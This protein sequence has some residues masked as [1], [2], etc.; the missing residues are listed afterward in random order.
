[1]EPAFNF[2]DNMAK[3]YPRFNDI[4]MS[5]D[6]NHILNWCQNK[7]VSFEGASILDIGAGTGTIAIP[8]AQKGAQVTAMDISEGMLAALN[9]D[10]KE[11]GLSA[12]VSTHQSDWDSFPLNQKYD[13]VIASMTPAISDLQKIEKMLGATKG[14]G[15]Y[16][17]WGKYRINKL[18]EALVKAHTKEEE[19]CAS[20]GCIKANQFIEILKEKNIPF[21]SDFFATSWVD[22]YTFDEAKEYSYDQLKRKEI[23]PDEEIVESIL[24]SF[25]KDDKVH[26]KTEAEKGMVLWNVA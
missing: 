23:T 9:E 26:V 12:K 1:M 22:M 11:Q 6:V 5:Q 18:V 19:D 7:N 3:R 4:T 10:A 20:G 16:V 24:V 2:W 17:G 14:I 8:L 13:I 25:L 21:E 15:I